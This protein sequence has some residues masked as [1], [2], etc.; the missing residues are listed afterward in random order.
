MGEPITSK[1]RN[2]WRWTFENQRAVKFVLAFVVSVD[3]LL[4]L[5]H[6]VVMVGWDAP[7]ILRIDMD[8][9]YGEAY[10][11]AKYVWLLILLLVYA[12]E[13]RN[14]PIVAW[15]LLVF[16][17]LVDDAL[18]IHERVGLWYSSS[19]WSF[20]VGPLSAQ[21]F[22]ELTMSALVGLLLVVPLVVG[23]TRA[24]LRTKEIYRVM[25]ALVVVLLVFALVV[26]A[27]HALFIDV[28]LIDRAL[29]F[30]E[31]M[32]E[33]LTLSAMVVYAFRLNV[34]GGM[35]GFAHAEQAPDVARRR[36]EV[37]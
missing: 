10:Q 22:G 37:V 21:T 2:T 3:I 25:V 36:S 26:D 29:G 6:V 32:G 33:M 28:K 23:Y 18:V 20:D 16:Y 34:K 19:S 30:V 1:V 9:S 4:M 35:P 27:V 14:W 24:D 7:D 8:G 11:Y 5:I 17:F 13:N 12:R 31:D 15:A